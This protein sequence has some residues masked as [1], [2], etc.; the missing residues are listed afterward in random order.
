MIIRYRRLL[1]PGYA[2]RLIPVLVSLVL[3]AREKKETK[4]IGFRLSFV[5]PTGFKPVTF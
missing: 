2:M 3:S 5:T 4:S 1:T